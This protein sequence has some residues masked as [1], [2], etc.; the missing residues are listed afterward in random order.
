MKLSNNGVC[1]AGKEE[2]R[3]REEKCEAQGASRSQD[4]DGSEE[5]GEEEGD[6]RYTTS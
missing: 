2:A 1:L 4:E 6:T 3:P 5:E